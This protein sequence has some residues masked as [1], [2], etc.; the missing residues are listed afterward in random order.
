MESMAEMVLLALDTYRLR[1]FPVSSVRGLKS[2]PRGEVDEK[3]I[4]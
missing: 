1:G 2:I 4:F 3:E